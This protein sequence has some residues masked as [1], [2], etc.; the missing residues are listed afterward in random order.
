[1]ST[2]NNKKIHWIIFGALGLLAVLSTLFYSTLPKEKI[3]SLFNLQKSV[4]SPDEIDHRILEILKAKNIANQPLPDWTTE[5]MIIN[6]W[7]TWCPPCI[8]ETPSLIRFTDQNQKEFQLYALSQDS[9]VKEVEA[10]LK[11]FPG[12][13][14]NFINIVH[15]SSQIYSKSFNVDKLPETFIYSRK[16]KKFLQISGATDWTREGTLEKIKKQLD[17]KD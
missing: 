13:T 16:T 3:V 17:K 15:D 9:S 7:A 5:Y 2:N 6:F 12:L 4:N 8:E 11:S 14:S 1:M 10:F